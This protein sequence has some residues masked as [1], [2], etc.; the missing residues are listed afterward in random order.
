MYGLLLEQQL[1]IERYRKG[2]RSWGLTRL[3]RDETHTSSCFVPRLLLKIN[4]TPPPLCE[5]VNRDELALRLW[6]HPKH[7]HKQ[8]SP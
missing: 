1:S 2:S 5:T 6:D 3:R 7:H 4:Q 8:L